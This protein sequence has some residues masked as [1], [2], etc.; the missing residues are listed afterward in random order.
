MISIFQEYICLC[1]GWLR[2]GPRLLTG[3]IRRIPLEEPGAGPRTS[4]VSATGRRARTEILHVAHV[5]GASG[6]PMSLV[7]ADKSN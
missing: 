3:A 4:E 2:R 1:D 7:K 5:M 6:E